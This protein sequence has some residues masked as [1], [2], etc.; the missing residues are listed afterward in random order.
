MA[1]YQSILLYA[2]F[3]MV[4]CSGSPDGDR[5][6]VL[7]RV[8]PIL[9]SLIETCRARGLFF[10]P[11]MLAQ[12]RPDDPVIY[13]WTHVEEA[14]RFALILFKA[15]V[16]F[17][18]LV[19]GEEDFS[20]LSLSDL[21]FPLPDNGYLW[22]ARP[23]REWCRRRDLQLKDGARTEEEEGQWI[24]RIFEEARSNGD[25]KALRRA[26]LRMGAWLGFLAGIEPG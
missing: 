23:I 4:G 18:R 14:K 24:S 26:W 10:Y 21:Q 9:T 13:T 16:L 11:A 17:S 12:A 3:A 1:T 8:R 15:S 22:G 25:R 20:P 19:D 6:G 5:D 2:I 7:K